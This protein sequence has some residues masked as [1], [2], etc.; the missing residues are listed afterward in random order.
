MPTIAEIIAAKQ[1]AK[2]APAPAPAASTVAQTSKPRESL[3][4]RIATDEAMDRIDPPGK[5]ERDAEV[6]KRVRGIVLTK[7]LPAG[8]NRGQ[9]TPVQGPEERALGAVAGELINMT[10]ADAS[11]ETAA[12][13]RALCG[14]ESELCVMRDPTDPEVCWLALRSANHPPLLVHRLPWLLW[15][16]PQAEKPD[17]QPF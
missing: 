10:P 3:A 4:E 16:Y 11:E 15:D 14:L 8:E 7:E 6:R 2:K 17:G 1:A 12:W 13:H 9:A 5:R